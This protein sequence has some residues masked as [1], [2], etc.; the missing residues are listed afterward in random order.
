MP[1][2]HLAAMQDEARALGMFVDERDLLT[3]SRCGLVEDVTSGGQL[4][5]YYPSVSEHD[6]GLR[7]ES[8]AKNKFR[9]PACQS[10]ISQKS[11]EHPS[12]AAKKNEK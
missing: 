9:C 6:S 1:V 3:C 8:V 10:V 12:K 5:T 11:P 4:I 2:S 7:F